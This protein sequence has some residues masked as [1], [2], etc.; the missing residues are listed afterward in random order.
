MASK[1]VDYPGDVS[2]LKP[3]MLVD[4]FVQRHN[5]KRRGLHYDLRLGT[6]KTNLFSWATNVHPLKMHETDKI[7]AAR[8]NVHPHAYG[9]FEGMIPKGYGHGEVQLDSQ[10]K[11]QITNVTDKTISFAIKDKNNNQRYVLINPNKKD[12]LLMRKRDS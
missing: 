8:T 12:G 7:H 3:G 6:E 1:H 10:G 9:S 4:Y 2:K 5:A 11:A